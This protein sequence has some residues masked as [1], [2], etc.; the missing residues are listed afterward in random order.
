MLKLNS[1]G[2]NVSTLAKN[3]R[4]LGYYTGPATTMFT[5]D[6]QKA[7][8][9]FQMQNADVEGRPLIVDGIVGPVT[10]ASIAQRL[11]KVVVP[12]VGQA[13]AISIAETGGSARARAA[14]AIAIQEL[15]AG[16]GEEGGDNRGPHVRQYL[17]GLADEGSDWCAGFVSWCFSKSGALPFA[18]TVGA[19]DILRQLRAKG[20]G[21]T[22]TE[23]DPPRPGDVV[24]WWRKAPSDWRGHVGLVH[25]YRGGVLSTIEGNKTPKVGRFSY[26][27]GKIDKLLGFARVT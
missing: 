12:T 7:V 24:V 2:T 23:L 8:R 17:N 6:V 13:G 4:A 19:R 26:T 18:Y 10:A 20:L 15:N 1:E 22:P 14:L 9:A 5:V 25:S 27:F 16:H 21:V 3:L 11:G